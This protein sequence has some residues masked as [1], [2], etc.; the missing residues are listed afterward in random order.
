M[1]NVKWKIV[2]PGNSSLKFCVYF[3]LF[4]TSYHFF[5]LTLYFCSNLSSLDLPKTSGDVKG[6][7][8]LTVSAT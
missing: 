2:V 1:I 8:S 6:G 7:V 3:G 4:Y 5:L